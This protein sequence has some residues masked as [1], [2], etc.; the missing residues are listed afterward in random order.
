MNYSLNLG[1]EAKKKFKN[2]ITAKGATDNIFSE[3]YNGPFF[4]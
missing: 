4:R 1:Q 3:N 2:N